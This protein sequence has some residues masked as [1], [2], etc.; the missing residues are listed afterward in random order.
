MPR[1]CAA[2][3]AVSAS[4]TARVSS[5]GMNCTNVSKSV[6]ASRLADASAAILVTVAVFGVNTIPK[7]GFWPSSATT[8]AGLVLDVWL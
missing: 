1:I 4:T 7:S 5:V 2:T 3:N 6:R 8:A